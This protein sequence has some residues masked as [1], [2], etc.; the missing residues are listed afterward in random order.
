MKD[1]GSNIII[2]EKRLEKITK[3]ILPIINEKKFDLID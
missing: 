1:K 3:L 2:D